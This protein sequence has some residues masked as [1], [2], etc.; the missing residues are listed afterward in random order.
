M[1][2]IL[3]SLAGLAILIVGYHLPSPML[4]FTI[5]V[6]GVAVIAIAIDKIIKQDEL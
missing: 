2:S 6:F 3:I 1:K 4:S 5:Q